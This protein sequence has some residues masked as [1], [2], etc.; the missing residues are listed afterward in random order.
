MPQWLAIILNLLGF[1]A[2]WLACIFAAAHGHAWISPLA[3]A[4]WLTTHLARSPQP[5][6]EAILILVGAIPGATWD[7]ASLTG[8]LVSYHGS[9]AVAPGFVVTFFALWI[10]FGTTIRVSFHWCWRRPIIAAL[11]GAV[12]GPFAY[13]SGAQIG[14]I[15][16]PPEPLLSY[17]S[18]AAQYAIALPVWFAVADLMLTPRSVP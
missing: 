14:A 4:L 6:R 9:H 11:M 8:G 7:I 10:N 1:K 3:I 13:W 16:F 2:C 5:R 15:E 17:L 18:I 12:G